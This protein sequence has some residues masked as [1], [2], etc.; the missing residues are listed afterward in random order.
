MLTYY[1][2][3]DAALFMRLPAD[4]Y[5]TQTWDTIRRHLPVALKRGSVT[6]LIPNRG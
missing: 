1:L 4:G 6:V 3:S 2:T 5:S